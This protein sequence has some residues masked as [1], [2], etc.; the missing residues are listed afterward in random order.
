MLTMRTNYALCGLYISQ[1]NDGINQWLLLYPLIKGS[2][3]LLG[4]N[5]YINLRLLQNMTYLNK[6]FS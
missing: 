6:G 1:E 5:M 2:L 4:I 3:W